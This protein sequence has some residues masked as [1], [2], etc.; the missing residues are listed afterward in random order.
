MDVSHFIHAIEQH[1][2]SFRVERR[3]AGLAG[4]IQVM[5]LIWYPN[6]DVEDMVA[7]DIELLRAHRTE[8]RKY[9]LDREAPELERTRQLIPQRT[10]PDAGEAFAG[11]LRFNERQ[12]ELLCGDRGIPTREALGFRSAID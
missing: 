8:V 7:E 9:L 2:V 6:F 3:R 10:D 11:N 5:I 12:L 1:G 4:R